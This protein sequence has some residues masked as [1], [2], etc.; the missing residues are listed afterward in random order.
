MTLANWLTVL[1]IVLIPFFVSALIYREPGWALAFFISAIVTDALDGFVARRTQV[2][3]LGRFLDPL[4]DKLLLATAFVLLPI[5]DG[6]PVWVT[7]VVVSRD[8]IIGLGYLLL[9]LHWG[10][11]QI[12]VRPLGKITTFLQS[13]CV[14]GALL[15]MLLAGPEWMSIYLAYL[16]ALATAGSGID[17]ILQGVLRANQLAGSRKSGAD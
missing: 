1:R 4:A 5:L 10:S 17:Y 8:V 13:V 11:T 14:G 16:A 6:I 15:N 3:S 7:V 12:K 9:Y 2:T